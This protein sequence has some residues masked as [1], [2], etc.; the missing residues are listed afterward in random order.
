MDFNVLAWKR[1]EIGFVV[2]VLVIVGVISVVQLRIGEM[3]TRDAQRT[4]DASLVARAIGAYWEDHKT[5]PEA[6]ANGQI[7][8]CGDR[9]SHACEWGNSEMVD[10]DGVSY[11]KHVPSDPQAGAGR[12]YV[13]RSNDPGLGKYRVYVAL[14][15]VQDPGLRKNLTTRCGIKVQCNW[16]VEY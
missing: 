16:Y 15:D 8:S 14:E 4:D 12:T 1:G 11:L 3:K 6:N 7:V 9:G 13:Y 2:G 10:V 5:L